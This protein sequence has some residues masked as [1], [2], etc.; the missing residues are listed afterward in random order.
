MSQGYLAH[1]RYN[2]ASK[3]YL[4]TAAKIIPDLK[5]LVIDDE[6]KECMDCK[7]VKAKRQPFKETRM[8][9]TKILQMVHSDVMGPIKPVAFRNGAQYIVTFTDDYSRFAAAYTMHNQRHVHTAL[10]K[11]LNEI[12]ILLGDRTVKIEK[13]HNCKRD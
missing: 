2:H 5:G 13:I 9:A 6:I 7:L 4:E 3:G 10:K 11:Y 12:R 8:R 1:L